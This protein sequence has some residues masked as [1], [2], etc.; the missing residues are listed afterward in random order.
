MGGNWSLESTLT[1]NMGTVLRKQRKYRRALALH[2]A[3][4]TGVIDKHGLESQFVVLARNNLVE[5]LELLHLNDDALE[6]L[7]TQA[8]AQRRGAEGGLGPFKALL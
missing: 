1:N 7:R 4:M 3:H 5:V 2:R 8:R 6:L